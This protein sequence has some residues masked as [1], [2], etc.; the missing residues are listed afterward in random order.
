MVKGGSPKPAAGKNSNCASAG[1]PNPSVDEPPPLCAPA[2][3][4]NPSVD[5]PLHLCAPAGSPNPPVDE[6]PLPCAPAGPSNPPVDEPP[7]LYSLLDL[8]S[9]SDVSTRINDQCKDADNLHFPTS[10]PA[11][12]EMSADVLALP[13][14]QIATH[15]D[16]Q[17]SAVKLSLDVP[18]STMS[19]SVNDEAGDEMS[20]DEPALP[21]AD[22]TMASGKADGECAACYVTIKW[23]WWAQFLKIKIVK[24]NKIS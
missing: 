23:H 3:P 11:A 16:A 2:G 8:S 24:V 21:V 17:T 6:P 19:S 22:T 9:S 1:P 12:D 13:Q 14:S 4:P 20:V 18:T 10:K 15:V 5:E 7:P